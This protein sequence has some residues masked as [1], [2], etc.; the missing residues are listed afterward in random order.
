[1]E[2]KGGSIDFGPMTG[3]LLG[4]N[5]LGPTRRATHPSF[6]ANC[7]ILKHQRCIAFC[8]CAP[9]PHGNFLTRGLKDFSF[10]QESSKGAGGPNGKGKGLSIRSII[11]VVLH[12]HRSGCFDPDRH[13]S[14]VKHVVSPYGDMHSVA[15]PPSQFSQRSADNSPGSKVEKLESQWKSAMDEVYTES[16]K[17]KLQRMSQSQ[18]QQEK[19]AH[20]ESRWAAEAA[21]LHNPS[22][23][24][25]QGARF[26]QGAAAS[27]F[28]GSS[29]IS[30]DARAG[31]A[32]SLDMESKLHDKNN[33][34]A[35]TFGYV[36]QK[37][38]VV[39]FY[40][41]AKQLIQRKNDAERAK[42]DEE[43]SELDRAKIDEDQ[44]EK[45]K[46]REREQESLYV[47]KQA[48]QMEEHALLARQERTR[49]EVEANM[50]WMRSQAETSIR[51]SGQVT[52]P[53]TGSPNELDNKKRQEDARKRERE[54]MEAL[55]RAT[56]MDQRKHDDSV[57]DILR[58]VAQ[59]ELQS[60]EVETD[61]VLARVLNM[62]AEA[63]LRAGAQ[64]AKLK[65]LEE[66]ALRKQEAE[67]KRQDEER[68][69]R[70]EER[71]KREAEARAVLQRVSDMQVQDVLT[72]VAK[73]ERQAQ[74]DKT[75]EVLLRVQEMEKERGQFTQ[76]SPAE[77]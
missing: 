30:T 52:I 62:E 23:V 18:A 26:D 71:N 2:K 32:S 27:P 68:L 10:S 17:Q 55:N 33:D 42:W 63:D 13:S 47:M 24:H 40:N 29:R 65:T 8:P 9:R 7:L 74:E 67:R 16:E 3:C 15:Q 60:A 75:R 22:N 14:D 73:M 35:T 57:S 44:L 53:G 70:E 46:Y 76:N 54:A 66:E 50:Q 31:S 21:A 20:L 59:L 4:L 19:I 49:L 38:A 6:L 69:R 5:P 72:R 41:W 64:R 58:R 48:A 77:D 56:G 11:M 43:I 12:M 51:A 39:S 61:R 28:A 1:M 34:P 37:E 45:V 36:Q 25:G